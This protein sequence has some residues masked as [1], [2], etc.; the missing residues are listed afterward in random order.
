MGTLGTALTILISLAVGF[1]FGWLTG[2]YGGGCRR[3]EEGYEDGLRDG[4]NLGNGPA[5][6]LVN[7]QSADH[8]EDW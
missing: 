2:K 5:P 3:Y 6:G 4:L 7:P 8:D 1:R